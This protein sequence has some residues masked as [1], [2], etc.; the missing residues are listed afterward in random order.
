MFDQETTFSFIA[1]RLKEIQAQEWE[2]VRTPEKE[3][4]PEVVTPAVEPPPPEAW[5]GEYCC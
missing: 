5:V 4:V 1:K 3:P 2:A